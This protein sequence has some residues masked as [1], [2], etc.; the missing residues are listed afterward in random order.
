MLDEENYRYIENGETVNLTRMETRILAILIR[1]KG[2]IVRHQEME[3]ELYKR[4]YDNHMIIRNHISRMRKKL[5][6]DIKNK[7][8]IGYYL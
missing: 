2:R 1:N 8:Q 4:V 6:L 3:E 7:R 5:K